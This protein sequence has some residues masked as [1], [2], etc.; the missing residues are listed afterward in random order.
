M[1]MATATPDQDELTFDEAL[2]QLESIVV[3]LESGKLSLEESISAFE[4]GVKLNKFCAG[5]LAEAERKIE[6]LVTGANGEA[7]WQPEA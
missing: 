3:Q 6:L 5:K 1:K 2:R 7:S 4:R